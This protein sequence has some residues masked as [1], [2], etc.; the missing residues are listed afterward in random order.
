MAVLLLALGLLPGRAVAQDLATP[1]ANQFGLWSSYEL[2]GTALKGLG[3]GFGAYHVDKREATLPNIGVNIPA[4][5]RFDA[6]VFYKWNRLKAQVNLKNLADRDY[7]GSQGYSLIPQPP[8]TVLGKLGF[9][10]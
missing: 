2:Q 9:T 1:P 7:Y 3:A 4:Y 5:W 8:F 10:S 6:S